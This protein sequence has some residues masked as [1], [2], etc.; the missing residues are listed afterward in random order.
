MT[1]VVRALAEVVEARAALEQA[2]AAADEEEEGVG[3]VLAGACVR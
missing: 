2:A 3:A 1:A